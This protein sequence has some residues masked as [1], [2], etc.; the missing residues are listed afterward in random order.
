[1][2]NGGYKPTTNRKYFM[3]NAMPGY[4]VNVLK[5]VVCCTDRR[6]HHNVV[7]VS[8]ELQVKHWAT[9]RVFLSKQI[10][11]KRD[12]SYELRESGIS[13]Q[14]IKALAASDTVGAVRVDA[15]SAVDEPPLCSPS[16]SPAPARDATECS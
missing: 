1:M 9:Q 10:D 12:G 4:V 2:R 5:V 7:C 13:P 8:M 16:S 3:H 14:E 6:F 11:V 15:I